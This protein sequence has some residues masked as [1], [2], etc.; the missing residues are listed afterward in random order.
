MRTAHLYP[1]MHCAGGAGVSAWGVSAQVGC[2]RGEWC[3]PRSGVPAWGCLARG[4]GCLPRG[5]LVCL[6]RGGLVCL[7]WMG[8]VWLGG[9][10]VCHGVCGTPLWREW[11][12]GVKTLPCHNFIAGGKISLHPA[13][14][15]GVGAP[16][17]EIRHRLSRKNYQVRYPNKWQQHN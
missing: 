10:G 11:Q 15:S 17:W 1:S 14:T 12:T 16:I 9:G 8:G 7:P 4:W 13:P 5:Q 2:L 6:P 3:L